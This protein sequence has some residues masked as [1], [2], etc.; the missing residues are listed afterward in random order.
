MMYAYAISSDV[1][2]FIGA[3]F[4]IKPIRLIYLKI[5]EC[6][7]QNGNIENNENTLNEEKLEQNESNVFKDNI[8]NKD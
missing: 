2:I 5:K 7:N 8:M 1:S 3:F 4:V 6:K